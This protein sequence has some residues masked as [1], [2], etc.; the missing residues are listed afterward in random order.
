VAGI[1]RPWV[2]CWWSFLQHWFNVSVSQ[3]AILL[4]QQGILPD[5]LRYPCHGANVG[6]TSTALM[7][8]VWSVPP[9]TGITNLR[10]NAAEY[11][12]TCSCGFFT[13]GC[14]HDRNPYC[15][16]VGASLN[17]DCIFVTLNWVEPPPLLAV[18]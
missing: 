11:S 12:C 6:S 2:E 15:R 18:R 9:A 5:R 3:L 4:V 16:C 17:L 13:V 10:F 14:R 8:S 7:A 1:M